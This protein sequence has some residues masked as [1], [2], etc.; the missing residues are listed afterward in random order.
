MS[1]RLWENGWTDLHE[2]F[3]EGVEWPWDDMI[4]FWV[5]S[6]KPRN[7]AMLISLSAFVNITSNWLFCQSCA[8][9]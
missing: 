9:I 4:Q 1:A 7:V 2:I 3:K 8:A 6:E 5:I